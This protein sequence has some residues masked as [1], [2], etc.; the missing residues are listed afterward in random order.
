[1]AKEKQRLDI[2]LFRRG[3]A[4][5]REKARAIIMAGEVQVN[6][7]M[8]DKPGTKINVDDDIIVKARPRFVSR[9]GEKLAGALK[10]FNF[11]ASGLVCADVGASTGGFTDC[12]LQNC[13]CTL[14]VEIE[15]LDSV[16]GD[17]NGFGFV[18][19]HYYLQ[20]LNKGKPVKRHPAGDEGGDEF[21]IIMP[22]NSDWAPVLAEFFNSG[23]LDKG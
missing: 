16:T 23:F 14:F 17:S 20:Y 8:R 15:I 10:D 3:L 18:D 22:K 1:L 21:G 9:G 6:G 13:C 2:E 7:E 12:L 5:S 11:D 19:I 4:P